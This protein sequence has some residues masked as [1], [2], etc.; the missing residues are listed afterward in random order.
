MK[1]A[2]YDKHIGLGAKIVKFSGWEMPVCYKGIL[3]EHHAVRNKAGIFDVSHM[4]RISVTG[5]EAEL[6]LDYLSTN[7]I[8]GKADFSATY[9]VLPNL[10]GG[11]IDDV[12]VYRQ[13]IKEYFVVVNAGNRQKDLEHLQIQ[14]K[15]FD[16]HIQDH[17]V[18]AGILAVQGPMAIAIGLKIFPELAALKPM[19]FMQTAY[20]GQNIFLSGT[21]YTGA[22]GFE[23]Y[24]SSAV[25]GELWDRFLQEG[26]PEGIEPAGLGARDTLRLEMGYALYG[27]ELSETIAPNES[28]SRWTVKWNKGNFLGKMAMRRLEEDPGK[29]S[30]HGLMLLEKGI[31]REGCEVFKEGELIGSVTSGTYSPT[32]NKSIAIILI[33]GSLKEGD[34]VEVQIRDQR[35]KAQITALPFI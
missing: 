28:V 20:Q 10:S 29:R 32:L 35:V 19:H 2:L 26:Q 3:Q 9:T 4:G 7:K 11:S 22:G 21:G 25:T 15:L 34:G 6:F 24:A 16:V 14:A 13:N 1:T 31:A 12:I 18:E 33:K 30:E 5:N 17:Y 8:G 23:I 27:H